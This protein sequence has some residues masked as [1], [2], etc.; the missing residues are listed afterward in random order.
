MDACDVRF[1]RELDRQL[2]A[3]Y[4]YDKNVSVR[5]GNRMTSYD[6]AFVLMTK[7]PHSV[8]GFRFHV[9]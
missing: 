8:E 3:N 9:L 6:V 1:W 5:A 7:A 4:Q 2:Y